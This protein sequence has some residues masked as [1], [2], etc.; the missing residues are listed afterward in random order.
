M[1]SFDD[2]ASRQAAF[3][4]SNFTI[5]A[6]SIKWTLSLSA[7]K[8]FG[9]GLI[10]NYQL[11]DISTSTTSDGGSGSLRVVRVRTMENIATYYLALGSAQG[12]QVAAVEVFDVAL[13]N[14]KS[15]EPVN[16]SITLASNSFYVLTLGFPPFSESLYY[17]PTVGLG[18]LSGGS[19]GGGPGGTNFGLI[20][21]L[22]IAGAAVAAFVITIVI[23]VLEVLRWRKSKNLVVSINLEDTQL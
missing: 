6:G 21:G 16:H 11:S 14:N 9:S 7:S 2:S 15:Y 8:P 12:N 20:I 22:T 1:F 17:D 18:V 5:N 4:R 13:V 3:G 19:T 10:I 23:I